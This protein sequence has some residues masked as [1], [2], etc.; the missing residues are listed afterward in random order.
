MAAGKTDFYAIDG[1]LNEEEKMMKDVVGKFVDAEVLPIVSGCFEKDYF[2]MELVPKLTKLG[3]FGIKT[4]PQFGGCGTS[5][6]TY[7]VVCQELERGDS[8]LRSFV[9]VQNSLVMYPIEKFGSEE[10]KEKWLPL[11]AQ[12]KKIGCFG[13]TEPDYGSNPG[14]MK[15]YAAKKGNIYVLNG[16]KMWITNGNIADLAIIWA[17]TDPSDKVGKSI[18]GFLVEKERNSFSTRKM[19]HKLSLRASETAEL[20]LDN[21]EIPEDNMLP[22]STV[23]MKA[24]LMCLNEARYGIAWGAVGAAIACYECALD[25]CLSRVQ[26]EGKPIASHQLVQADLVDMLTEIT[27]AQLVAWRLGKLMEDKKA[28]PFQVSMAKMNNVKAALEIARKARNLLGANG[29]S[30]EYP[31]IRHMANL[32]SVFTYEG[33]DNIHKLAIGRHITGISAFI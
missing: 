14:G 28:D 26:F 13:L 17:K 8:G 33:T 21:V 7:G 19:L 18:R 10:Q 29:I 9:S 32:E 11:L 27:K 22:G 1:L 6:M 16:A 2:P 12:G 25:Y 31:V 24:F 30:L 5:H 3:L 4:D 15:T 20:I 23:G